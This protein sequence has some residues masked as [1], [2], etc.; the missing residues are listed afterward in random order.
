MS[1]FFHD[2]DLLSSYDV[3]T[4]LIKLLLPRVP[5]K[6]KP[7]SWNAAK[8]TREYECSWKRFW[9]PT[10]SMRFWWITQWFK[11]FGDTLAILRTEGIENSRGAEPLQSIHSFTLLFSEGREKQS[12]RQI[13]LMSM[14]NH[15]VGIGTCNHSGMTISSYLHSE[16]LLHKFPD[17]TEFQSW[18][19]NFQV[20]VCANAKN[21]ALVLQWI[22]S[23]QP[24]RWRTSSIQNQLREKISLI[25]KSWIW[26]WR[27]NWNGATIMLIWSTKLPSVET[28]QDNG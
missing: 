5:K 13:S 8:Y 19:V 16:M 18:I 15:A 6:A 4:F 23:M 9:S 22:K 10:C 17:Q 11:K 27:Q 25:M 7:R 21:L 2:P 24:A 3:L 28:W 14:T 26:W 20:E 12:R 1:L